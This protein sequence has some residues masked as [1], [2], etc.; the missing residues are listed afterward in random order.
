MKAMHTYVVSIVGGA[1]RHFD[2]A[3]DAVNFAARSVYVDPDAKEES[4][5]S[6]IAGRL[7]KWAYG[8]NE[9]TIYPPGVEI[10]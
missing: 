1:L 8:F 10:A 6:L 2:S 4:V 5:E 3:Y 7:A 9:V